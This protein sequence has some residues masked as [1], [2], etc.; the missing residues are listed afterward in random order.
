MKKPDIHIIAIGGSS[1]SI[2][3]L[4]DLISAL[5][6]GFTLPVVIIVHRMKN[7]ESKLENVLSETRNII[8][9][10][11]KE[12]IKPG[13][14][15]LAPQ[16]YHLLIEENETFGLDYSELENFS[17]PSIDV[18]FASIADV[19]KDKAMGI[20]LSGANSDGAEGLAEII[21]H[22]GKAIVLDPAA[23]QFRAMPEAAIK[24]CPGA[25][26][27]SPEMIVNTLLNL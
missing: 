22:G 1:G 8:E 3:L 21:A 20:L 19:Y 16:N 9:P 17:R 2:P 18:T 12:Q 10:E 6:S 26:V 7:V 5:P 4:I 13:N 11:D 27:Y 24:K 25:Y 15:Y 23:T 14:I